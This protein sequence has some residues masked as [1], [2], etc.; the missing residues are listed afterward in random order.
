ML[1]ILSINN[2]N[3]FLFL[4]LEDNKALTHLYKM[5]TKVQNHSDKIVIF[6]MTLYNFFFSIINK[7]LIKK[8]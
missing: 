2:I 4:L 1:V 8:L 7:Y 5:I 6:L 3:L